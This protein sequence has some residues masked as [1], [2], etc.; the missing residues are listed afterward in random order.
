LK[1]VRFSAYK[2][3]HCDILVASTDRGICR[4]KF[5]SELDGFVH[6]L[7]QR[8][9]GPVF[10]DDECFSSLKKKLDAY[11]KGR[12]VKFSEP[13][14]VEGTFFQRKVWSAVSKIPYGEVRAYGDIAQEIGASNAFRAVGNAVGRNPV[15][16]IIPCHRVVKS[17][18]GLGG[19]SAGVRLKKVL[20]KIEGHMEYA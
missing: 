4:L 6:E 16:L 15:P 11:F 2:S 17:N 9:G 5:T 10:R 18:G 13:L 12:S 20:L 7:Q 19:F 8:Y 14:D 3:P 1:R